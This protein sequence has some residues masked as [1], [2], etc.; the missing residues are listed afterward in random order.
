M[1]EIMSKASL[2]QEYGRRALA[3]GLRVDCPSDGIFNAEIAIVAEAPGE[4]EK[5]MRTP[6]VGSSGQLLW[7]CLKPYDLNRRHVYVSNVIKKQVLLDSKTNKRAPISKHELDIWQGLIRWELA[8]LPNLKYVFILGKYALEALTDKTGITNWRGSV[9]DIPIGLRTVKAICAFNPAHVI[10]EPKW[11]VLFRF[12][13]AKLMRVVQGKYREHHINAIINPSPKEAFAFMDKMQDEKKPVGFDVEFLSHETACVGFANDPHEGMC[14]NY[15]TLRNNR[16]THGEELE[17]RTRMQRLLADPKVQLVAQN[18]NFDSHWLW[19]KDRIR[20]RRVWFDTLLAHHL[21]YPRLPHSLGFLTAQ[22]TDHPFY[23][24]EG[25]TWR[26][27]GNIDLYWNYNVKDACIAIA[28]QR[29]LQKELHDQ[30]LEEFFHSHVMHLQPH[31]VHMTVHGILVDRSLKQ[32]IAEDLSEEVDLLE[33]RFW[34]TVHIATGDETYSPNPRSNPQMKKLYFQDLSLIGKGKSTDKAN[35]TVMLNNPSTSQEAKDVLNAQ[36]SYATDHKFLSV[37]VNSKV[38]PDGRYRCDYKQYGTQSA[39][40]RLSSAATLW[41]TGG[42]LQNQPERARGMFVADRGY[43][44]AYFDLAQAEARVVGWKARIDTWIEQF[45]RAR[46]NPG[47]YDC[48]RALAAD[49][50]DIPYEDTPEK[51]WVEDENGI[52]VPTKRYIAK[53][54]RHGLN[55]RMGIPKLAEV[56]KLPI[57]E[58]AQIWAIYHRTTP[59]VRQW[60]TATEKEVMQNRVLFNAFGRRLIIME[61]ITPEAMESIIAFYPQSTIGDKVCQVIY[62]SIEDDKWPEHSYVT[63]NVHDALIALAPLAKI[64]TCLQIMKR[65]AEAPLYIDGRELIIPADCKHAV[66]DDDG[67]R[68]WSNLETVEIAA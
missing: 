29:A 31:L 59:E 38:D 25:K 45:E 66:P 44:L 7:K 22:Y 2:I 10:R 13:T 18:G 30:K 49:M 48:H 64:K 56:T 43:G 47:S 58:A 52:P 55:Y 41:E 17:I 9:L 33:Q 40:G 11:E 6:L 62:Q 61:R 14:I 28:A 8:Q 67:V 36:N 50:W 12:D 3:A 1:S 32:G 37:Y 21:L 20:V 63:L 26:E 15:R 42:N 60:W 16:F 23:K 35:R 27:G 57:R 4:R 68:R 34:D 53:R 54:C 19:F 5:I 46:L 65:Y 24:D 39:P 51:D